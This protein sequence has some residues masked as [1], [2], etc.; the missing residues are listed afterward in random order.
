MFVVKR[1][2][3]NM[4]TIASTIVGK[5][6]GMGEE[7]LS[8]KQKQATAEVESK[9]ALAK[10]KVDAKIVKETKQAE[11]LSSADNASIENQRF[12]W[13]DEYLKVLLTLP[14]IGMF[15]PGLQSYVINGFKAFQSHTPDWY[16]YILYGIAISEFGL[17]TIFMRLFNT[18]MTLRTGKRNADK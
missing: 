1:Q 18:I 12:T 17:R 3:G 14:F 10:A 6:F 8:A 2:G 13:T 5:L 9:A 16:E 7:W 4:W 15:I 11:A